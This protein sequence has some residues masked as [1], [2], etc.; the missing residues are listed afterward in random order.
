[1]LHRRAEGFQGDSLHYIFVNLMGNAS[2]EYFVIP[3]KVVAE[4]TVRTHKLFLDAGG[5]DSSM[6]SLPNAYGPDLDLET[7]KNK[8]ELLE[9]K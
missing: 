9:N 7:Y 8:W 4:Y 6:R 3:S 1:V 5:T 2:P